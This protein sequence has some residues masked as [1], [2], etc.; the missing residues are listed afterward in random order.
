M[1]PMALI[2]QIAVIIL[3]PLAV[4]L[5]RGVDRKLTARMQNR[6]GPPIVQ[7]FYDMVKLLS[8]SPILINNLQVTFAG[9]ALLFQA[10]ALALFVAGGDLLIAFFVSGAG[11]IFL[12][13]GAFSVRSPYSYL[14]GQ[15]ELLAILA[16]EPVLFLA[17]LSL[18]M[19]SSFLVSELR[20]GLLEDLPL[21]LLAMVPVMV[22]LL[23]KS[24]YDV[25]AAHQE[26]ISGPYI[27]YSGPYLAIMEGARW[28]QLAFVLGVI[29]LFVW[30]DN[31][32]V[33]L[34]GKAA[35][36]LL[37]LFV[38]IVIDNITARLTR[39]RM[40]M[41]MLTVGIALVAV[42]LIYLTIFPEGLI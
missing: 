32:I 36:V 19:R 24:P 18:G 4:G 30:N 15:R 10:A 5:L 41:F 40:V 42:N 34:L 6:R 37:V 25:P 13:L 2:L 20:G 9:A 7:P 26:L 22:I 39:E 1:D 23:E 38:T 14:G 8:K 35:I 27:E 16:Y 33:S 28:F 17:V 11:S 12:V 31:T 21:V 3:A 29:T